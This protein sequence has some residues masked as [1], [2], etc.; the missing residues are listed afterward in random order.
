MDENQVIENLLT[1]LKNNGWDIISFVPAGIRGIDVV[2]C[3]K[4]NRKWYIEAKGGTSSNPN[5][6][7]YGKPYTKSQVFDVTSKGLM[8]CF[9]HIANNDE[10]INVGFAYPG[11]RYFGDYM[12]PI[13]PMLRSI[14]VTL[15][16][17]NEDSTVTESLAKNVAEQGASS[18][19][20]PS[21]AR[22]H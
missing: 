15:F 2:T 10:D 1:H 16:C 9:H 21:A 11:V 8:Q 3:D 17:V 19:A 7:R 4:H 12:D 6:S 14:G 18:D 22:N 5:S 20:I 13:K